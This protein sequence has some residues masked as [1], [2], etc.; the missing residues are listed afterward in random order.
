[1]SCS[2]DKSNSFEMKW[3]QWGLGSLTHAVLVIPFDCTSGEDNTNFT[4]EPVW[5]NETIF[6]VRSHVHFFGP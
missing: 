4:M 2:S 5:T 6:Q 1:M 3:Q